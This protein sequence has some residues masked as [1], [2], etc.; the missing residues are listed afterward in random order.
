MCKQMLDNYKGQ[1]NIEQELTEIV[2]RNERLNNIYREL[3]KTNKIEIDSLIKYKD[4]V[5]EY[6]MLK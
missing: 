2:N 4:K 5:F 3:T 1:K 6:I